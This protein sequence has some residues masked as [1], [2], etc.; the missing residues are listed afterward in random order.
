[1]RIFNKIDTERVVPIT[2]AEQAL[3]DGKLLCKRRI[4]PTINQQVALM[5]PAKETCEG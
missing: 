4:Y 5:L 2:A 3:F 1:M